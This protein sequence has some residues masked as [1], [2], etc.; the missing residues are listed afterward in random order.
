MSP[1]G[2]SITYGVLV[3]SVIL[4]VALVVSAPDG[5]TLSLAISIG[6]AV[7]VSAYLRERNR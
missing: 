4:L 3:S 5:V 1:L 6:A 2:K 7:S